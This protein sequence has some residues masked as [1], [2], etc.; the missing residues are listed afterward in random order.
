MPTYKDINQLTEETNIAGTE[1]VPV[2]GTKFIYFNKIKDWIVNSI[3]SL[4]TTNYI[5]KWDSVN[6][7]FVNSKIFDNGT[8]VGIGTN[9]PLS[10]LDVTYSDG[11]FAAGV[12]VTNIST[13]SYALPSINI[14]DNHS[15]TQAQFCYVT[16]FYANPA[17]R[18]TVLFNSV[19]KG[20]HLGFVTS[21]GGVDD[22]NQAA[23]NMGDIYFQTGP[24]AANKHLF[25]SGTTGRVGV[26]NTNPS[27]KLDVVGVVKSSVGFKVGDGT[28]IWKSVAGL[29][30]TAYH[31]SGTSSVGV[32][33]S[34]DC[35]ELFNCNSSTPIKTD[36]DEGDAYPNPTNNAKIAKRNIWT[37]SPDVLKYKHK[38]TEGIY[39][40]F[41]SFPAYSNLVTWLS[42]ESNGIRGH[43]LKNNSSIFTDLSGGT[44]LLNLTQLNSY[45]KM[46]MTYTF[47]G[48]A[49]AETKL[50]LVDTRNSSIIQI[51]VNQIISFDFVKVANMVIIYR[52]LEVR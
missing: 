34:Y 36:I 31:P 7:R 44:Y 10:P 47:V 39:G 15:N 22:P 46:G 29:I 3:S 51:S 18:N 17:L 26:G 50:D 6:K 28:G 12:S 49:V 8:N 19:Y 13:H 48:R 45:L 2:S 23:A 52:N 41:G 1:K 27:E 21:S 40:S 43:A 33:H 4:I 20:V 37:D 25:I 24:V 35:M 38:L 42:A 16:P 5:P 11:N 32:S 9:N 14:K 30:L